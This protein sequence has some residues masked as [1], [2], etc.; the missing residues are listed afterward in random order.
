[1]NADQ[2]NALWVTTSLELD[3]TPKRVTSLYHLSCQSI[4]HRVFLMHF[5]LHTNKCILYLCTLLGKLITA[6]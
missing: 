1:M 5:L 4:E 3:R 6:I 2:L